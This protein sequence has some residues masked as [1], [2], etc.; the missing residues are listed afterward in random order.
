[1]ISQ[2]QHSLTEMQKGCEP[3]KKNELY[4]IVSRM[5]TISFCKRNQR[6]TG[7]RLSGFIYSCT[8]KQQYAATGMR[9]YPGR[10]I[11]L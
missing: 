10:E 9:P 4:E 11:L 1:M 7:N 2:K 5:I 6:G 8:K 3:E